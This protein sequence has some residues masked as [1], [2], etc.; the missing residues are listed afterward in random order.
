VHDRPMRIL[1]VAPPWLPVPPYSYGGTET[2]LDALARG[3]TAAGHDVLLCTT[4]DS[5][6]PVERRW[7]YTHAQGI[8]AG[9]AVE[10]RHLAHAYEVADQFDIVHDHTLLGPLC[11]ASSTRALVVTT[12][13]GPFDEELSAVYRSIGER[14]PIIAI[15]QSQARNASPEVP[16]AAVIPHGID[17][18]T[19]PVGTDPGDYVVF[20]G[21]MS[22]AKGA[23]RAARVA[24]AAGVRLIIAAKMREPRE[25]RYFEEEVQ[26]LL[27]DRV[28]FIG[29]VGGHDKLELLAGA[30]ALVNPIAW[31]EPFGLVM[32][33]AMACGTPVLTF[34]C[35]AAPEIVRHGVTGFLCTDED[36]MSRRLHDI[37][38]LDRRA[39][40]A[41]VEDVFS[42]SRMVADHL[43]LYE[44]LLAREEV[45]A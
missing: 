15:S 43:A 26:P 42:A 1:L 30:R 25:V 41:L 24:R 6:C 8:L 19:F 34:A 18:E 7:V 2:V 35:G 13:H 20:L 31:A 3:Y 23:H 22:P 5:A 40:R 32:I 12:N 16:I 37:E 45:A 9:A 21:R 44:K 28:V 38:R 14:V 29:E 17:V 33:E 36:D 10:Y 4:G 11:F 39:C 27:D